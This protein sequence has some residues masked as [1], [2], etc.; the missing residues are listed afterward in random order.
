MRRIARFAA[1]GLLVF[2]FVNC[3]HATVETGRRPSGDTVSKPWA[4]SF[5]F[6]LVPPS[7]VETA[8]K[9]PNGVAKVETQLSFLNQI[10]G[11]LTLGI[12]TPMEIKA[13]CA[14]AAAASLSPD[15][16]VIVPP[17]GSREATQEAFDQAA[18]ASAESG[19]P[20]FVVF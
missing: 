8:S 6:G 2:A 5:V 12:F 14:D 20:A 16:V 18:E 13:Q 4:P 1:F 10:V 9:C 11:L 3:Y 15:Q 17:P 7:T 19:R